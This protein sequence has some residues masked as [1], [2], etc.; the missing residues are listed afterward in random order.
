MSI[1]VIASGI[2]GYAALKLVVWLYFDDSDAADADMDIGCSNP[3]K[4]VRKF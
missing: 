2:I 4:G 1:S 3:F